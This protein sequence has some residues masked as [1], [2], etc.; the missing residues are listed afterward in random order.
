MK[1][2]NMKK[3]KSIIAKKLG[4]TR[5]LTTFEEEY[6]DKWI[7]DYNYDLDII[8]MA[9][10]KSTSKLNISFDY[11]DKIIS[12][13]HDHNLKTK[14]DINKYITEFKQKQKNIKE[15]EKKSKASNTNYQQRSYDNLE[16]LYANIN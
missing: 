8:E 3:S 14:D 12:N 1:Q 10:K 6:I 2:E 13:W 7:S 4:L 11:I 5:A 15:L 9:L 16:S